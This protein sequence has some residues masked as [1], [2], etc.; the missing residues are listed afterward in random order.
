MRVAKS[1]FLALIGLVVVAAIHLDDQLGAGAVKVKDK[2]LPG[3]LAPKAQAI[4]RFASK[5]VPEPLLGGGQLLPVL[6]GNASQLGRDAA[7]VSSNI[8]WLPTSIT[9]EN[10]DS[11]KIQGKS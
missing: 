6:L 7:P 4:Q 9:G 1:I 10:S 5:S 2:R 11:D 3:V 8:L